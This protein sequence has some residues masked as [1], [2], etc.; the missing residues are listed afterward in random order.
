MRIFEN[1]IREILIKQNIII[2]IRFLL[3]AILM[4]LLS[5]NVFFAAYS[6]TINSQ[7]TLFLFAVSL[8]I[9]LALIF[10]YLVLQANRTFLSHFEG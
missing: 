2:G 10:I 4:I 7:S 9:F 8:K 5:F 3:L 1:K 6:P